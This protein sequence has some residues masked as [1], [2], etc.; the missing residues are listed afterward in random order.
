MAREAGIEHVE[1]NFIIGSDPDETPEDVALTERLV[2]G[3]PWTFVSVSVIVPFP[4]TP[5][6][7]AM[8]SRGLIDPAAAWEDY[9]MFGTPPRWHTAH[10]SA[11]DLVRLQRKIT[12]R[13]YLRPSYILRQIRGIRSWG[14]IQY[15]LDAGRSYLQWYL[16]GKI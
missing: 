9:E 5:V 13:F 2:L 11:E 14:D 12:G 1:G 10:F 7:A 6:R 8:E 3:L 15:W 4:G 16:T